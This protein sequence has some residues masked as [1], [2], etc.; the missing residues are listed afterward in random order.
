[1][2]DRLAAVLRDPEARERE[3]EAR[4]PEVREPVLREPVLRE[5]VLREDA[6]RELVLREEEA[7]A[8]VL[9]EEVER[10]RLAD[11]VERERLEDVDRRRDREGRWSRGI[12]VRTMSLTSRPSSDVRNFA[13]RSSSRRMLRASWAVSRSPTSVA[14]I[15]IRV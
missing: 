2:R 11:D 8:P 14:K 5:P 13:I 10:D 12:S 4:V 15:S 3:P 6:L 7:R 1:M 9:R